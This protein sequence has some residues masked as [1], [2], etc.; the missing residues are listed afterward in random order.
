MINRSQMLN[1][2]FSHVKTM[3][4]GVQLLLNIS[5]RISFLKFVE[6]E[7]IVGKGGKDI[8]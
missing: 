5:A 6:K 1:Q 8:T 2:E 4:G 3:V 7:R